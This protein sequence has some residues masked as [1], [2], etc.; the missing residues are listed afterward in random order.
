MSEAA[1]AAADTKP[2]GGDEKGGTITIRV[3]D[4]VREKYRGCHHSIRE[5]Y[6][7]SCRVCIGG[8]AHRLVGGCSSFYKFAYK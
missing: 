7:W 8:Y 1:A 4:Q 2:E 5:V 6:W 3:R